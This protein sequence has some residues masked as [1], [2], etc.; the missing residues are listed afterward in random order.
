MRVQDTSSF[1]TLDEK[2]Y[3]PSTRLKDTGFMRS[4]D[5]RC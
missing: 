5:V 2:F 3:A 1:D 4:F